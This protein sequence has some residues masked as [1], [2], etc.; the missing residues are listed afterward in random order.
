SVVAADADALTRMDVGAAL[1]DQDVAGQNV[2]T[3]AALHAQT[4][5]LGITAVFGRTYA[6]FVCHCCC[7]SL[8]VDRG[9]LHLGVGLTMTLADH[10]ALL[11]TIGQ[12]VQLL[13]LAVLDDL[14][15]DRSAVHQRGAD[16]DSAL[17]A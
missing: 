14:G 1:T 3:V 4:L 7:T 16:L 2:L 13:A 5:G 12:D 8:A 6:F 17:L 9:D 10:A 15:D 11:G